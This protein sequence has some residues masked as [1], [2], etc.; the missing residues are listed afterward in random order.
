M[1]INR[2]IQISLL[3][4]GLGI[5]AILTLIFPFII[6]GHI[7]KIEP[8]LA[9]NAA[10]VCRS[11][12]EKSIFLKVSRQNDE[13]SPHKR[14]LIGFFH[15]PMFPAMAGAWGPWGP[16]SELTTLGKLK[17]REIFRIFRI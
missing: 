4:I 14:I 5:S 1:K 3:A 7:G 8:G 10:V 12:V 15:A 11:R 2:K 6:S 16:K 13:N 17:I 9:F